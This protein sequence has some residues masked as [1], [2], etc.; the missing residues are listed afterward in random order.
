VIATV[1]LADILS[2]GPKRA[3]EVLAEME[4]LGF[5]HDQT[6]RA[7]EKLEVVVRRIGGGPGSFYRREL[8]DGTCPACGRKLAEEGKPSPDDAPP[9]GA[10]PDA[11]AQP[12]PPMDRS[13][14]PEHRRWGPPQCT[15]CGRQWMLDPGM[16]CPTLNCP[17][18]LA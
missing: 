2:N 15:A 3:T 17:G 14:P 6:R 7:R 12:P 8:P 9:I 5:S 4:K 13:A 1:K 16:P 11:G 18:V 10:Y